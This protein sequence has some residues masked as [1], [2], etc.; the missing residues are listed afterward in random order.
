MFNKRHVDEYAPHCVYA[1][2]YY[3]HRTV[4]M[5]KNKNIGAYQLHHRLVVFFCLFLNS[6]LFFL[7][8]NKNKKTQGYQNKTELGSLSY[9]E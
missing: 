5:L 4:Q 2:Q 9:N 3:K 7:V 8:V 6:F 1:P